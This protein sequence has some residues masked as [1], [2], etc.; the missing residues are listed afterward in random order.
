MTSSRHMVAIAGALAV[1]ASLAGP[2]LADG[3][4]LSIGSASRWT[5]SASLDALTD[6][7]LGAFSLSGA[8]RLERLRLVPGFEVFVGG[9]FEY[10]GAGGTTFQTISTDT[11]LTVAAVDAIA[12]RHV[13][14]R[15]ALQARGSVGGA[16][17]HVELEDVFARMQPLTDTGYAACAYAGAGTEYLVVRKRSAAGQTRFAFGVRGELG[18]LA[19]APVTMEPR[20]GQQDDGVLRIPETTTSVGDLDVSS[21]SFRFTLVGRF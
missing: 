4:E 14:E 16:R 10:G 5:R 6:S 21:W 20:S 17:V 13:T 7:P 3:Y 12:R 1:L 19:V 2:A 8:A 15:W 18:Y 11:S 9:T